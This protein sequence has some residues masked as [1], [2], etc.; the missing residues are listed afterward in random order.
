M[1]QRQEK[2]EKTFLDILN[3]I[4]KASTVVLTPDGWTSSNTLTIL[5]TNSENQQRIVAHIWPEWS[6]VYIICVGEKRGLFLNWKMVNEEPLLFLAIESYDEKRFLT[7]TEA[8]TSETFLD[9]AE[10]IRQELTK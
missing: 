9:L 7:P 10:S 5:A 6:G 8:Q 3:E 4:L 1:T 2:V